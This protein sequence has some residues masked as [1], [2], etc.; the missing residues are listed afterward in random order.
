MLA[1]RRNGLILGAEHE[2]QRAA[3]ALAHDDNTAALAGLISCK[4]TVATVLFPIRGLHI[5]AEI[6]A[7]D[8]DATGNLFAADLGCHRFADFVREH[9]GGF[10][11]AIEIA[12]KLKRRMS[13]GAVDEDRDGEEVIPHRELAAREDGATRN[14]ELVAALFAAEHGAGLV[15]VDRSAAA[16]RAERLALVIGPADALEGFPSLLL[17]HAR[18]AREAQR[19]GSGGEEEVLGHI[20]YESFLSY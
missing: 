8:L 18:N 5:A 1:D 20:G 12:A 19:A 3:V 17:R 16:F 2:W 7:I 13:L 14:G 6:G 15:A 10:V 9:E 11:L 4:A